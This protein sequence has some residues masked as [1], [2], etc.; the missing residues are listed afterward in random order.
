[1]NKQTEAPWP[2]EDEILQH[3]GYAPADVHRNGVGVGYWKR[4]EA[5]AR[6]AEQPEELK[7][8]SDKKKI[9]IVFEYDPDF[10]VA[11]HLFRACPCCLTSFQHLYY[12][13]FP[14]YCQGFSLRFSFIFKYFP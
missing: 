13:G 14:L 10:P 6:F 7:Y 1:M 8:L 4:E 12:T 9:R 2:P 5:L 3:Y 11:L